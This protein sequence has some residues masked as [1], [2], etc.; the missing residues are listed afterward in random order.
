VSAGTISRARWL[1]VILSAGCTAALMFAGA[2]LGGWRAPVTPTAA[3]QA[4]RVT[5]SPDQSA[6]SAFADRARV[7]GLV[8]PAPDSDEVLFAP[9]RRMQPGGPETVY[10]GNVQ[11][12]QELPLASHAEIRVTAPIAPDDLPDY[13]KG[14]KITA[15]RFPE[16][17]QEADQRYGPFLDRAHMFELW[18]DDRGCI[19]RMQHIFTP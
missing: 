1:W 9:A 13:V 11:P 12:Y 18:F 8:K 10:P 7:F 2:Q 5:S 3:H 4:A 14:I 19:V 16:M 6:G 17:Y 15:D